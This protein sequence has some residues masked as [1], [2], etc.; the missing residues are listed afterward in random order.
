MDTSHHGLQCEADVLLRQCSRRSKHVVDIMGE[1]PVT[2]C[3]Q[4][5]RDFQRPKIHG[6]RFILLHPHYG[7]PKQRVYV[8]QDDEGTY[9]TGKPRAYHADGTIAL[10]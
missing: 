6:V 3:T 10:R 4:H 7:D 5:Y 2:L 1:V 8:Q 9:L